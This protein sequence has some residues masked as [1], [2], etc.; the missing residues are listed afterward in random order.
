VGVPA[1]RGDMA[2]GEAVSVSAWDEPEL[3][4]RSRSC[5]LLLRRTL[6]SLVSRSSAWS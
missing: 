3:P 1:H 2:A 5:R 4:G 6:L